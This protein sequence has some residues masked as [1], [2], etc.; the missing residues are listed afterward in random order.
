MSG[1]IGTSHSKSKVI[2]ISKDTARAWV[3]WEG[4][5]R[6]ESYNVAG[7]SSPETGHY[8]ITFITSMKS[9]NYCAVGSSATGGYGGNTMLSDYTTSSVKLFATSGSAYTAVFNPSVLVFG[10]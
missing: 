9:A 1:I 7:I 8:I 10:D 5:T 2:G 4:T 6:E 3:H